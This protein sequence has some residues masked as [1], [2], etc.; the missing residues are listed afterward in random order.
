M[1]EDSVSR[2]LDEAIERAD[3]IVVPGFLDRFDSSS[4]VMFRELAMRERMLR[5]PPSVTNLLVTASAGRGTT[6]RYQA[7]PILAGVIPK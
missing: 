6:C 7:S 4:G 5:E 3:T 2:E 1:S